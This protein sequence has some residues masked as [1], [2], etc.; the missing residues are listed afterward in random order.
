[1]NHPAKGPAP[2]RSI[3]YELFRNYLAQGTQGPRGPTRP[4]WII[5]FHLSPL[6]CCRLLAGLL[7]SM[8]LV[9]LGLTSG[10]C[11]KD[12]SRSAGCVQGG[13]AA[14][15]ISNKAHEVF[16]IKEKEA[17]ARSYASAARAATTPSRRGAPPKPAA[18]SRRA[19]PPRAEPPRCDPAQPTS[20]HTRAAPLR[21]ATTRRRAPSR[22]AAEP[23]CRVAPRSRAESPRRC[24]RRAAA[25]PRTVAR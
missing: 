10:V 12:N 18:K 3:F 22:H 25:P 13:G 24:A 4:R 23:S 17:N 15:R 8:R 2:P 14:I 6:E 7:S 5:I 9:E 1:M 21:V 20:H 11:K 19:A 16:F